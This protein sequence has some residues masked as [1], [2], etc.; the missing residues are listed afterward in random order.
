[1]SMFRNWTK[2]DWRNFEKLVAAFHATLPGDYYEVKHDVTLRGSTGATHQV[3]VLLLPKALHSA[4]TIISCK[5]ESSPIGPDHVREWSTVV[6]EVA[7][8][9]GIIVSKSG[10]TPD[11]IEIAKNPERRLELWQMREL[12]ESDFDGYI[13]K[14]SIHAT[15]KV[16]YVP[17]HTVKFNV[18]TTEDKTAKEPLR[19]SIETRDQFYLRDEQDNLRENL[20][21]EFVRFYYENASIDTDILKHKIE[22]NEP[23]FLVINGRRLI[24]KNFSFEIHHRSHTFPI[25]F[26]ALDHFNLVYENVITRETKLVPAELVPLVER[27]TR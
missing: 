21:D 10:F 15:L 17:E 13:Q 1:M 7:A 12:T 22:F 19:F 20:W 2:D 6:A 23:R 8:A 9:K 26:D 11:A 25:E 3:D 18:A 24:F 4:P 5:F 16:P 14:V 27:S